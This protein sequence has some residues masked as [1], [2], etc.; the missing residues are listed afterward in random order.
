MCACADFSHSIKQVCADKAHDGPGPG[1]GV[2]RATRCQSKPSICF[3]AVRPNPAS[4]YKVTG[5]GTCDVQTPP[6]RQTLR[7]LPFLR[8][9]RSLARMNQ[10]H[11]PRRH[12]LLPCPPPPLAPS[13][14]FQFLLLLFLY[15][16]WF[17]SLSICTRSLSL[18]SRRDY[19]SQKEEM[20]EG[21]KRDAS[22]LHRNL[23]QNP[24]LTSILVCFV[25]FLSR[26]LQRAEAALASPGEHHGTSR[27]V[28]EHVLRLQI[29][30]GEGVT[31]F[32]CCSQSHLSHI[33]PV[34]TWRSRGRQA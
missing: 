22:H 16:P 18:P 24:G 30:R 33:S 1:P 6:G 11:K 29:S 4:L 7:F 23:S 5:A 9:P 2:L 12:T 17:P 3:R 13:T 31:G 19:I 14:I 21:E 15:L 27:N 20:S 32:L 34:F 8:Q 10:R 25:R 26:L 28:P